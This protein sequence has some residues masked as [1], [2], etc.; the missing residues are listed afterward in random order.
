[1][2]FDVRVLDAMVGGFV[3]RRVKDDIPGPPESQRQ[4]AKHR[5]AYIIHVLRLRTGAAFGFDRAERRQ[6]KKERC[7]NSSRG[8]RNL[9]ALIA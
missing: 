4:I 2:G 9:F 5:D 7:Q 6:E 1:M 8:P 3:D